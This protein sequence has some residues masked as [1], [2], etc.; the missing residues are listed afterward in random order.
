MV[1]SIPRLSEIVG[2]ASAAAEGGVQVTVTDDCGQT[3]AEDDTLL[4][5]QDAGA[6][7]QRKKRVRMPSSILSELYPT[8]PSP[9]YK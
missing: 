2:R 9:Y 1:G 4:Q 5:S 7:A 3:V 8:L 6:L